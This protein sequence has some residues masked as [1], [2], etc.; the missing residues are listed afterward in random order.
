MMLIHHTVELF[1]KLWWF[2][3]N[4]SADLWRSADSLVDDPLSIRAW[5]KEIAAM[6]FCTYMDW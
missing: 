3:G 6:A 2:N 1:T 5:G 4:P